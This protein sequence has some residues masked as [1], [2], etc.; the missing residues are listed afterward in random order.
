MTATG[1]DTAA[2]IGSGQFGT[3][4]D[5]T[6]S[7]GEVTATGGDCA[8]GIG[9]GYEGKFSS[10]TIGSGITSV[11]AT[12]CSGA[13]APIGRGHGNSSSGSV[14][15]D[16]VENPSAGASLTNLN[17]TVSTTNNTNDTWTLTKKVYSGSYSSTITIPGGCTV[18]L[19]GATISVTSVPAIICQGNAT[20]IL[21]GSSTV[22]TSADNYPAIQAGP[23]GTTLT[24]QGSGSLTATGGNYGAGIGSRLGGTCGAISIS[25][26]TV[27]ATGGEYA[28]GIGSGYNG[29]TC[30]DITI[31]GG[32]VTATGGNYAAG[33][34]SGYYNSTCGAISI[35]GGTVTATGK[36]YSA[37]IG[38]GYSGKFT[39]IS[40]TSGITPVTATMGINAQAPIGRGK[41]DDSSGSVTID[42]TTSWTAGEATTNLNWSVTNSGKTW[43][44]TPR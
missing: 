15:I 28:A 9:S 13:Q 1:G 11:T 18:T 35:S 4:G 12:M 41:D 29:S 14:T 2:G 27:E 26:G 38:S 22:S 7:G 36:V 6:I 30:G 44:L 33:I 10:I 32:K 37:G 16:D 19:S 21:Q 8:A 31:S 25:G 17:F 3:C 20:I 39:S 40:I 23:S 42:E 24:I 43:T 5:I 34:G